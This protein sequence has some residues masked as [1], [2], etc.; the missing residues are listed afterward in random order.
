MLR[1]MRHSA[2]IASIIL[3]SALPSASTGHPDDECYGSANTTCCS[4]VQDF[5]TFCSGVPGG[6]CYGLVFE[7]E[8]TITP[9]Q[10]PPNPG[11]WT[12]DSFYVPQGHTYRCTFYPPFCNVL[13]PTRRPSTQVY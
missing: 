12:D 3:C 9:V 2:R 10:V 8:N 7:S 6:Y 5:R 4:T 1:K 13:S 11:G